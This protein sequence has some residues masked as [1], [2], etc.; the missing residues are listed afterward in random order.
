MAGWCLPRSPSTSAACM[1]CSLKV[2]CVM[3]GSSF[4]RRDTTTDGLGWSCT[5]AAV[6]FGARKND[7]RGCGC[8]GVQ[9]GPLART[10]SPRLHACS[11]IGAVTR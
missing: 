5:C 2:A 6:C 10:I 3:R 1:R 11:G 8:A 7:V 4:E 9:V